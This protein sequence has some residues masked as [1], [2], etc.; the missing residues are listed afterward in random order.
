MSEPI[1]AV[2]TPPE[3]GLPYLAVM[4]DLS[5]KVTATCHETFDEAEAAVVKTTAHTHREL[6]SD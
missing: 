6:G 3:A 5:G 4:I 2:Y 1:I